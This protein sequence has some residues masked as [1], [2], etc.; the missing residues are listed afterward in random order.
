[1]EIVYLDQR[2]KDLIAR[3]KLGDFSE[4][5]DALQ[6]SPPCGKKER[7]RINSRS[8][9]LE[10]ELVTELH[11]HVSHRRPSPDQ[12][13]EVLSNEMSYVSRRMVTAL[14]GNC[15]NKN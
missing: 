5:F 13:L 9:L 1:M 8:R 14:L 3:I 15:H 10:S 2:S 6:S 12:S 7:P 11:N 4:T